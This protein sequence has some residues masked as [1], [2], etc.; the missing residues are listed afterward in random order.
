MVEAW[1]T[2]LFKSTKQNARVY[3]EL[4]VNQAG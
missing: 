2:D 3:E 4:N 1:N